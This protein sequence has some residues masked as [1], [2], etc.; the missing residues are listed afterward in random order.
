M[1]RCME[2]LQLSQLEVGIFCLTQVVLRPSSE[3]VPN[4]SV[5]T[6]SETNLSEVGTICRSVA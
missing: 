1:I 3:F 5:G 4:R 2:I 6:F